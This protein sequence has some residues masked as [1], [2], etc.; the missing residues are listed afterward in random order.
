VLATDDG[1]LRFAPGDASV[2]DRRAG[3]RDVRGRPWSLD[4]D[5]ALLGGEIADGVLTTRDYPDALARVWAGLACPTSGDVLLSAAP[6]SEFADWGG[7]DHRG[8]GSHGSLHRCDSLG[9]LAHCGIDVPR[10]RRQWS[11]ADVAPAIRRHFD[12]A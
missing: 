12:V 4:G 3:L 11:I 6:G 2:A 5:P 10:E 1:E 7:A 9:A 8:G